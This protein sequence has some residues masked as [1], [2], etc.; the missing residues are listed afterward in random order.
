MPELPEVETIVRDL[1]RLVTGATIERATVLQPDLIAGEAGTFAAILAGQR[2]EEISRRAKNLVFRLRGDR[3]IINLGMTG[4]VLVRDPGQD[5]P[6]HVGV[7]FELADGRHI[8]YQ[9]VRRFG[10]L[11]IL[12]AGEWEFR[13]RA[14][15]I[16]PLSDAFD[17]NTL[18]RLTRDSRVA[19][20]TWL[21]DQQR[22]VG[23]GNIYAS[24]ALFRARMTPRKAARRLTR[25]ECERLH[26]AIR[27]VL[28]EAIDFRGTT[29]LD[30][31]DAAGQA[32]EFARR[33]RVYD[34]TGDPCLV[35]GGPIRRIVQGGRSTFYCPA[36]QT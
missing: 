1:Q 33:L 2:I 11:Q 12:P 36:C 18:Y 15:G 20:K 19:I 30:Y 14:L 21:M 29:L 24:E 13:A 17:A 32:G 25:A 27:Q 26:A 35:C 31:R 8:L 22:V 10:Y 16:E 23:I 7:R 28:Q 9:D 34:R 4:R 3:L 6:S 5:E